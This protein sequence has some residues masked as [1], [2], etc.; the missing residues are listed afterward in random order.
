[1]P[2]DTEE[3]VFSVLARRSGLERSQI[4]GHSRLVQ[5]L[6][7]D[8]DDAIDALLEISKQC[9]MEIAA[10][11]TSLYFRPEPNLLSIFRSKSAPKRQMT[12]EQLVSAAR[13]GRL[14]SE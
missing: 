5:D 11:D 3:V 12:V 10:F 9:N 1:M 14:T 13:Q 4:S 8:G 7:L 2:P 6:K